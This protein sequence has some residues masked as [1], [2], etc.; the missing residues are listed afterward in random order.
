MDGGGGSLEDRCD[1]ASGALEVSEV[2]LGARCD[3]RWG[4][5]GGGRPLTPGSGRILAGAGRRVID[6]VLH[7]GQSLGYGFVNYSDPNDADKAINTLNGL[8]LQTKTIKVGALFPCRLSPYPISAHPNCPHV[9]FP[10][11]TGDPVTA[12][13]PSS[14]LT[15]RGV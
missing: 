4:R 11:P 7:T 6:L 15:P 2:W 13:H 10:L 1:G 8:K 12:I 9:P 5:G 3:P 14:P